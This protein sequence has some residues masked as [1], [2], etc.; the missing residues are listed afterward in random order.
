M[1]PKASMATAFAKSKLFPAAVNT[2][3][4]FKMAI[5]LLLMQCHYR[6]IA[7]QDQLFGMAFM[8]EALKKAP[9]LWHNYQ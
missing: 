5:K 4:V 3:E 6:A 9:L 1:M 8:S 7:L 2:I